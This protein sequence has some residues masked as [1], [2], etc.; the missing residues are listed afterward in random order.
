MC[1]ALQTYD[2]KINRNGDLKTVESTAANHSRGM[3]SYTSE[4]GS[5]N[6]SL[7]PTMT[8]PNGILPP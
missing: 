1:P 6:E 8:P 3:V 4:H 5:W 7:A 2:R